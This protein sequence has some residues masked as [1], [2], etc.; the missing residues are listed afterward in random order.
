MKRTESAALFERNRRFIPGGVVSLNRL[1]EPEIAFARGQGAYLWDVDGNRY[2]DYHA[3]F[4]PFLLGH[5]D[6][7]VDSAVREAMDQGWALSGSGAAPWEGRLA[8]LI[9]Q[10]VPTMERVQIATSG[11]E[12]SYHALRL[13][14][15][16]TGRDD[17]VVMQGGYNGWHDDVACNVMTPLEQIGPRVSPG[18]Y[19][20]VPLS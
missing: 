3:G 16:Y 1:V 2:I 6:P 20:Y 12:A 18:E 4:A 5:A 7:D 14:R 19:P 15:A 9:L 10:C 8:E 13:S 17:V 11:S